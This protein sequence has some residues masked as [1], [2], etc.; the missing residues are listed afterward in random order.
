MEKVDAKMDLSKDR[1][2]EDHSSQ[3]NIIMQSTLLPA[4]IH[5]L[6]YIKNKQTVNYAE[7]MT[8]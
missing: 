8:K 4:I 3:H 5:T 2:L 7:I 6:Q 1:A